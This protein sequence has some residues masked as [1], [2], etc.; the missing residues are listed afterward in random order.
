MMISTRCC[1]VVCLFLSLSSL[2][3]IS[4]DFYLEKR[5]RNIRNFIFFLTEREREREREVRKKEDKSTDI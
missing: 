4:E 5:E 1:A 3:R 2:I